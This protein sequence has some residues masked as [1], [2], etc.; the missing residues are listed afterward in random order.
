MQEWRLGSY[1][2]LRRLGEGGMAQVYLARDVRLGREVAIKVLDRHLAERP[3]FRERFLREARVAAAFDHPNIV[4]LYDFGESG[5]LY[6]VMP[7][8]SGGSLQ[9]MLKRAPFPM[10]AVATYGSQI[11]DALAYAHHR[12]VIHRDVKPANM[13][14][15]ADGRVMLSDFGLAKIIDQ[16]NRVARPRNHPDA[17][18]PEYMAP[19]Q[20]NGHSDERSDIYAL[21][22]VLYL[23]LTGRLP[24]TGSSTSAVMEGHLYRM[25]EAPRQYNPSLSAAMEAV[26]L[27]AMAKRPEDRFQR[28]NELGAALLGA[29]IVDDPAAQSGA[30][31][32]SRPSTPSYPYPPYP[33]RLP[34]YRQDGR[35]DQSGRRGQVPQMGLP[36]VP[37]RRDPP[38]TPRVGRLTTQLSDLPDLPDLTHLDRSRRPS[39]APL[40]GEAPVGGGSEGAEGL[41]RLDLMDQAA[42]LS[43]TPPFTSS[44]VT[45]RP[46]LSPRQASE[47]SSGQW[48]ASDQSFRLPVITSTYTNPRQPTTT[49]P[50]PAITSARVTPNT[51]APDTAAS[52]NHAIGR[53]IAEASGS[54]SRAVQ[55]TPAN[56]TSNAPTVA[57]LSQGGPTSHLGQMDQL[58]QHPQAD[59]RI[60][61]STPAI[62]V[63]PSPI[64]EGTSGGSHGASSPLMFP[65]APTLPALANGGATSAGDARGVGD[66]FQAL[67]GDMEPL[68]E[69]AYWQLSSV[70]GTP[71][72]GNAPR[73][74]TAAAALLPGSPPG[75][76]IEHRA[77]TPMTTR[78]SPPPLLASGVPRRA[79]SSGQ[80]ARDASESAGTGISAPLWAFI[81]TLLIVLLLAAGVLLHWLQTG[82]TL[83]AH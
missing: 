37:E 59:Q 8:V 79:G 65:S 41:P 69:N 46:A 25:P 48:S 50:R 52:G 51:P 73:G 38:G 44:R 82:G 55:T 43:A 29:L 14:L 9:D 74:A 57:P 71:G 3:G 76:A 75:G 10:G 36:N 24:F 18:T 53:R 54:P 42:R 28:A 66:A 77:S 6:L 58:D 26:I 33:Q 49:G 78:P 34:P 21:G 67:V 5:V 32:R 15:H 63:Y 39:P 47:Q 2:L 23:L 61:V 72:A 64:Y 20:I 17:G 83:F 68:M 22:V 60:S 12:N 45:P 56:A 4:P 31:L 13:L 19:E 30:S 16:T 62:S 80:A 35:P 7:Y 70:P 40:P 27:R 81:T 11:A 1:E